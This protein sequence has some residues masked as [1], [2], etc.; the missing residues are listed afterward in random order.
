M[1]WCTKT[2][3][4]RGA[5]HSIGGDGCSG[6]ERDVE[7]KI[8]PADAELSAQDGRRPS[9]DHGEQHGE[10]KPQKWAE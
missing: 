7:E 9:K 3:G 6:N 1:A 2:G 5:D 8:F 10:P 4:N